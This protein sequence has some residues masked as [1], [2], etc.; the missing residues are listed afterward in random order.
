[1]QR[2]LRQMQEREQVAHVHSAER[3]HVTRQ[4]EVQALGHSGRAPK[5]AWCGRDT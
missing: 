2:A 4:N 1:M 5:A 3:G